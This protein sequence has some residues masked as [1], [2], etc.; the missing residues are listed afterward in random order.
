MHPRV[1]LE[2]KR[3]HTVVPEHGGHLRGDE[4]VDSLL[5]QA[6]DQAF[7][8]RRL[9]ATWATRQND[10]LDALVTFAAARKASVRHATF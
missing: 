5:P 3:A 2:R 1:G 9:A 4:H 6:V 7:E 8:Q 10:S